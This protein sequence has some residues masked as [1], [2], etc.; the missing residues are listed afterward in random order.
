[1]AK[2]RNSRKKA[3]SKLVTF[4]LLIIVLI[5]VAWFSFFYT[6]M[7]ANIYLTSQEIKTKENDVNFLTAKL[8]KQNQM[9]VDIETLKRINPAVPAYDNYKQIATIL[10]VILY[11]SNDYTLNFSTPQATQNTVAPTVNTYR[12]NVSINYQASSYK[13]AKQILEEIKDIPFRLQIASVDMSAMSSSGENVTNSLQYT[14]V[15]VSITLTFFE[16]GYN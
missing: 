2:A 14:P 16:N 8:Q 11:Q 1:M 12:R 13:V 9:L 3:N 5:F 15:N 6:P 7:M 10:G 4:L